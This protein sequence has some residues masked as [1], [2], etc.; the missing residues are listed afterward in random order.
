MA[1]PSILERS[2]DW[3]AADRAY[4]KAFQTAVSERDPVELVTILRRNANIRLHLGLTEEAMELADLSYEIASRLE[5]W[6]GAG[7]AMNVAAV[8]QHSSGALEAAEPLYRSA[9][10]LALQAEDSETVGMVFQNL[11][12]VS[13][14]R[15]DLRGARL[16]YLESI[17]S[18]IRSGSRMASTTAYNNLGMVCCDL[19]E[20]MEAEI[21]FSRGI[22]I[23]EQLGDTTMLGKLLGN[24]A[25][26]LIQN[27]DFALALKS[28]GEAE[29][30]ALQVGDNSGLADGRRYR[31]RIARLQHDF[32]AA[33]DHLDKA[34][35]IAKGAALRLEV[36]EVLEEQAHVRWGEG[37]AG[38]ARVL[39]REAIAVYG[40][41][42]AKNDVQRAQRLQARWA[43]L[44]VLQSAGSN[45]GQLP[46]AE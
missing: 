20:W 45:A 14:V 41:V 46:G 4:S 12:V 17:G 27:G 15:G 23:A 9:L 24:R 43:P 22:E 3:A 7:R 26:A 21:Y 1:S 25:E 32:R 2:G 11:G 34:M 29:R 36:G 16:L 30:I 13:N 10:E 35:E 6:E 31:G 37:R 38:A 8:I 33:Q 39:L 19:D 40:E 28:L 18:A 44:A 5:L 42:G